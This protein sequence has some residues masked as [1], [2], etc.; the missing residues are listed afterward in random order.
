MKYPDQW[1]P[2]KFVISGGQLRAN[3]T[4]EFV[5]PSSLLNV[6][7]LARALHP[8][9]KQYAK[10]RLVDLGCGAVPLFCAY[11]DHIADVCCVDWPGGLHDASHIDVYAD[12]NQR[13]PLP[14]AGFDTV[15]LTDVLEHLYRPSDLLAEA[16]RIIAPGGTLV[17][18]VPF[19]YWLHEEPNDHYRYTRHALQRMS[20]EAGWVV[21]SIAHYGGGT[22]VWLDVAAKLLA[23]VHWRFGPQMARACCRFGLWLRAHSLGQRLNRGA[24]NLPIGYLMILGKPTAPASQ[25]AEPPDKPSDE[26]QSV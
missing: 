23:P 14:D 11:R 6:E 17:A 19:M 4:G 22:D 26:F 9:I 5:S 21:H 25:G 13:L 3:R 10:G 20:Q 16:Y 18:S 12:L 1:K 2:S 8:A 24:A 7:L 15:L